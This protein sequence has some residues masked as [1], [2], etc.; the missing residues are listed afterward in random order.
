MRNRPRL[1]HVCEWLTRSSCEPLGGRRGAVKDGDWVRRRAAGFRVARRAHWLLY[2]CGRS[3]VKENAQ[4]SSDPLEARRSQRGPRS[5]PT[6]QLSRAPRSAAFRRLLLTS[7]SRNDTSLAV[8]R[9]VFNRQ[10]CVNAVDGL[11]VAEAE[12][13]SRIGLGR[14]VAMA[15][16]GHRS[17]QSR[18]D[19]H[20]SIRVSMTR[21][22]RTGQA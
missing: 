4:A 18:D 15:G 17:A 8:I 22:A 11:A 9:P 2:S 6:C 10:Q 14:G 3:R 5:R 21:Y 16:S 13:R 20:G 12:S 1:G 19:H 7:T